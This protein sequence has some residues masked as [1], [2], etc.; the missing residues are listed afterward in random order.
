MRKKVS[1]RGVDTEVSR[2]VGAV[3]VVDL[4]GVSRVVA[5]A[6]GYEESDLLVRDR[7]L[8]EARDVGIYL[9]RELTRETNR[10]IG[11]HF[12]GIGPAAVSLASKRIKERMKREAEFRGKVAEL[13]A[14]LRQMK[15]EH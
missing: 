2:M 5:E 9:S 7:K 1:E 6:Y 3:P 12:G 10:E 13:H 8:H 4:S 11:S 14:K 15:A